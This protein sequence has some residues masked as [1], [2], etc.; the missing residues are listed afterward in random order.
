MQRQHDRFGDQLLDNSEHV[1]VVRMIAE[2][3]GQY[4]VAQG[5]APSSGSILKRELL[6]HAR[7]LFERIGV[8]L[9]E[10]IGF[11]AKTAL[12]SIIRFC[13]S[14]S[15]AIRRWIRILFQIIQ[16]APHAAAAAPRSRKLHLRRLPSS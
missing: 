2:T 12:I 13:R 8:L 16:L 3:F 5:A 11:I 7:E 4:A 14:E 15:S 1:D 9:F 6:D 10:F